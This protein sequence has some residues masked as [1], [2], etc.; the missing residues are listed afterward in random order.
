M[1]AR[2]QSHWASQIVASFGN[3]LL[4]QRSDDSQSNLGWNEPLHA[5]CG[6]ASP[7]GW[8]VGLKLADLTLLF[9]DKTS[10]V[11]AEFLLNGET[12]HQG[13]EWLTATFRSHVGEPPKLGFTL[14]DY[15]MP[16]HPVGKQE[17]FSVEPA[18]GFQELA[19]WYANTH[20]VLHTL[21][22]PWQ[23]ASPV[24]CWPHYFDMATLVSLPISHEA[25]STGLVGCGM[26]PGD[27]TYA[28]P[29]YYVT[30]WPYPAKEDL[31]PLTLGHWRTED[32]TGAILK[33]S[34]LIEGGPGE[35]QHH[36]VRQFFEEGT[37]VAF[38]AL[39]TKPTN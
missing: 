19:H 30:I 17:T 34:D 26:S 36:R 31:S 9:L 10:R 6:Q 37:Q 8:G 4:E 16:D 11:L 25:E 23:E 1:D 13:F 33:A 35:R 21:S 22:E 24:R 32:W 3:A 27:S 29:Y 2:L 12:L 28:Q 20:Q 15:D 5:L 14:R 38:S 7:D 39:G 18:D